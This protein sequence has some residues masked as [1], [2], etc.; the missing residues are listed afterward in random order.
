MAHLIRLSGQPL[1]NPHIVAFLSDPPV[2][3]ATYSV[4]ARRLDTY[5]SRVEP[6]VGDVSVKVTDDTKKLE[7]T[8]PDG[9]VE[10]LRV[11]VASITSGADKGKSVFILP[12]RT[13]T[14]MAW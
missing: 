2:V 5:L 9:A 3:G 7:I 13:P 8:L 10:A 14:G 1:P 6:P 11:A 4:E 12:T